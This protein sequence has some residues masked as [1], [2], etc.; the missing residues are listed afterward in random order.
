MGWPS[1]TD[2]HGEPVAPQGVAP[3]CSWNRTDDQG[4][5]DFLSLVIY[6]WSDMEQW[7]A[8][9]RAVVKETDDDGIQTLTFGDLYPAA[10]VRFGDEAVL[11][12]IGDD[13]EDRA[14]PVEVA[15]QLLRTYSA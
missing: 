14:D 13:L 6:H 10:V 5:P 4:N 12:T 1:T 2:V 11:V 15:E 3:A 7:F 9:P 8:N